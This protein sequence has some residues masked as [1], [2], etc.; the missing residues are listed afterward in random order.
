MVWRWRKEMNRYMFTHTHTHTHTHMYQ[1]NQSLHS[2]DDVPTPKTAELLA[3]RLATSP[4]NRKVNDWNV[5]VAWR[6]DTEYRLPHL[7]WW[8]ARFGTR[9]PT[10]LIILKRE[11]NSLYNVAVYLFSSRKHKYS[12]NS[13]PS[14]C[15]LE[16]VKWR[17]YYATSC[18]SLTFGKPRLRHASV[19]RLRTAGSDL[20]CLFPCVWWGFGWISVLEISVCGNL[21]RSVTTFWLKSAIWCTSL[22]LSAAGS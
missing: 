19:Y 4:P 8:G 7:W 10:A 22:R 15:F 9:Q 2:I 20:A 12:S 13:V 16:P 6:H 11:C 5:R 3:T 1:R 17:H 18:S 14:L 21:T